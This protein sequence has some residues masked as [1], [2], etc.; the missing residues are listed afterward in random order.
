MQ[1]FCSYLFVQALARYSFT[2][3]RLTSNEK[4][5]SCLEQTVANARETNEDLSQLLASACD[6]LAWE[7]R[8]AERLGGVL[9]EKRAMIKLREIQSEEEK[10]DGSENEARKLQVEELLAIE[11]C[12]E[13][14][15]KEELESEERTIQEWRQVNQTFIIPG[16][17]V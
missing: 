15:L 12:K 16:R 1:P 11:T 14:R 8:E 17:T 2:L 3:R 5:Q 7:R 13:K 6:A 9:I 10:R 4:D